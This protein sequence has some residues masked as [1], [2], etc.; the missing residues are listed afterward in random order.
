MKTMKLFFGLMGVFVSINLHAQNSNNSFSDAYYIASVNTQNTAIGKY[1]FKIHLAD[2]LDPKYEKYKKLK[3]NGIVLTFLGAGFVTG[4]ALLLH[5]GSS[6]KKIFAD[7][8]ENRPRGFGKTVLGAC[9]V[10]VGSLSVGGGITMWGIGGSK[11]K[12]YNQ[13]LS[14]KT[15]SQGVGL[16]FKF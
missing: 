13:N 10:I 14:F 11:M 15:T 12:K 6:D 8:N 16:V 3:R 4:G 1:D 7:E 5:S 2:E 9:F